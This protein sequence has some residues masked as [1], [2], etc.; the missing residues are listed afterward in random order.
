MSVIMSGLS[1]REVRRHL[2]QTGAI[3]A[4]L[5]PFIIVCLLLIAAVGFG[6]WAYSGRQDYKNNVNQKVAAAVTIAKQQQS[7][8]DATTYAQ[9][10]KYPLRSYTGPSAYGSVHVLYP[11][12]WSAYVMA[13]NQNGD[14]T[15]LDGYFQPSYVPDTT[16]TNNT[17]ALRVKVSQQSYSQELQNY[18]Q[19]AQQGQVTIT[20]YALPKVPSVIGVK[21]SGA[22]AQNIQGIM[23]ILPLRDTTLKIWTELPSYVADFNSIILPNI[24]FS[25]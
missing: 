17:F 4:L 14:S 11:K 15:P 1:V 12:T 21:I 22:I 16:N 3:N 10:A 13:A 24:S 5:L 7:Q 25:P 6:A 19:L 20:P 8:S 9:E 23:V 18:Q 2:N